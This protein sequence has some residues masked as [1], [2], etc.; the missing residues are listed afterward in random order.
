MSSLFANLGGWSWI[1]LAAILLV[2]EV[3]SPGIFLMWF[4]FA[5]AITGVL[6]FAFDIS[7]QWQLVVL[8]ADA[9]G[10]A[11]RPEISAQAS[12]C[13]R[14]SA[15]QRARGPAYRPVLRPCRSDRERTWQRE[16]RGLD[17][18]RARAGATEGNPRS[19]AR[20]RRNFAEGGS[21][22]TDAPPRLGQAISTI[23]LIWLG[24]SAVASSSGQSALASARGRRR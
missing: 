19:C 24:I 16:D 11:H 9:C 18:A 7:W 20:L 15:A 6:A 14:A 10:R 12:A 1:I 3:T 4:G 5:A 21:G 8:P 17:L 13:K 22:L 23:L 2:L